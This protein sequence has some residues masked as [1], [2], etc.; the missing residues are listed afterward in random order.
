MTRR[1][2]SAGKKGWKEEVRELI[3]EDR[4][5]LKGLIQE[6]VQE[7][8]EGEMERSAAGRKGGTD[9]ESAGLSVWILQPSLGD[10]GGQD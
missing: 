6:A 5:L 3:G 1:Q 8:L 4:D 9:Q 2:D 10:A 7:I